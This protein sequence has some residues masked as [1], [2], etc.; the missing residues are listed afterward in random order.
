[1][2]VMYKLQTS[3]KY[4]EPVPEVTVE[5]NK[6]LDYLS[7]CFDVK[8]HS[9]CFR[10]VCV[11]D[12]DPCWQDS[13]VEVFIQSPK[14]GGYFNFETNSAG[15][16]LAEFG[17]SRENRHRFEPEEYTILKRHVIL[18]PVKEHDERIHWSVKIEIPLSLLG[19]EYTDSVFGNLYKCASNAIHPVYLLLFPIDTPKPDYH[20]PEFFRKI[21]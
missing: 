7:F 21:I 17:Q 11:K 3:W 8:E 4:E 10:Q 19:I 1:M 13:C 15:V 9:D 18:A 20:R 6:S 16:T 5:I 14:L 2:S 12:G